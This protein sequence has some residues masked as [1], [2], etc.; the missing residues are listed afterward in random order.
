MLVDL[1]AAFCSHIIVLVEFTRSVV[2]S[3]ELFF[4]DLV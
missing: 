1:F 3:S 4:I 2:V